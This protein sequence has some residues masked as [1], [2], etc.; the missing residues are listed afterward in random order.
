MIAGLEHVEVLEDLRGVRTHQLHRK[1]HRLHKH[2]EGHCVDERHPRPRLERNSNHSWR[3][4]FVAL[5]DKFVVCELKDFFLLIRGNRSHGYLV[6][7]FVAFLVAGF[8]DGAGVDRRCSQSFPRRSKTI[9]SRLASRVY[10]GMLDLVHGGMPCLIAGKYFCSLHNS[11]ISFIPLCGATVW[12][13]SS[14][15]HG[16]SS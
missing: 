6:A 11:T 15:T 16:E 4:V 10:G 13:R 12:V 5:L 14:P 8:A 9:P 7:Y 1:V 2:S 3:D